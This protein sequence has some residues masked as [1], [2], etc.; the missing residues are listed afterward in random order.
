MLQTVLKL[1]TPDHSRQDTIYRMDELAKSLRGL[2]RYEEAIFYHEQV[3]PEYMALMG[4]LDEEVKL[5]LLELADSYIQVG[6]QEKALETYS[7]FIEKIQA[8][9]NGD[10]PL[11]KEI[12]DWRMDIVGRE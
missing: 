12:E 7:Y 3:R 6:R 4:P 8:V 1:Q 2:K 10:H 11:I 9:A 5:L